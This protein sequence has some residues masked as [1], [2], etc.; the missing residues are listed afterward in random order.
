MS[1]LTDYE[2]AMCEMSPETDKRVKLAHKLQKASV[3][4]A[5][6][7]RRLEKENRYLR[8]RAHKVVRDMN[9]LKYVF[10]GALQLL[11]ENNI[12]YTVDDLDKAAKR[13]VAEQKD[14]EKQP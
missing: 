10:E 11:V 4:H 2:K 7:A 12:K 9:T 5:E 13:A 8:T 1:E 14:S 3:V 6:W